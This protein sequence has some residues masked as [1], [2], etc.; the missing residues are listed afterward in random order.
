MKNSIRIRITFMLTLLIIFIIGTCFALN[1]TFLSEY[2]LFKQ[3][4]TL[5]ESFTEINN[6]YAK[7]DYLQEE[8]AD[9]MELGFEKIASNKNM[10][11]CIWDLKV[12][13]AFSTVPEYKLMRM[14]EVLQ[15]YMFPP[16]GEVKSEV[17]KTT[18]DYV[19][20][21]SFDSRMNSY[22]IDLYGTLSNGYKILLRLDFASMQDNVVISNEFLLYVGLAAIIIGTIA[23]F[24]ISANIT[25]PILELSN[26][27]EK[28]SK[29]DFDAK[30]EVKT[31]DEIGKLGNSINFLSAEL[32]ATISE[33]KN[34]NN[35]L[36]KDIEH[37]TQIDEM[38]KDFLSNV[39]HEL[40][41][42]IALI[43]GYAEGLKDNIN[44]DEESREF[45][46]D[47]IIDESK[48]MNN[49]VKKL[50]S[51]NQIEFGQNQLDIIRFDIVL[52]IKSVLESTEILFSQKEAK[53]YF[54][55]KNPVY[56]WADEFMI[57]EVITNFIS[58]ALNHLSGDNT[59]EI[60]I[61]ENNNLVRVSVFNTGENIPIE[62]IDNIWIKFYKVD[63]ARTREYGG[64]GIGL[65][66][67][68][69][70][71]NS[72]NQEFGV[73]NYSNGVEFWF[74]LDAN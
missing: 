41:T 72:H 71:M 50:L 67:V 44:D 20:I 66:I 69:A 6:A 43:Q 13:Y 70:I 58:N 56:V 17:L 33:L 10:D 61:K 52:L 57:E 3:K 22:Y 45:Y 30:Y 25:K 1:S 42:P 53:L 35:E 46:C 31:Q 23:M 39:S 60:K 8:N 51:L 38:R 47:V 14:L 24:F 73:T 7:H 59:I 63:K 40:K 54:N 48:K 68:K 29:L 74:E 37:K 62:D 65:S 15:N 64:S 34:A 32:K 21:K 9:D 27:A 11:I 4:S 19:L 36:L 5:S 2:Y 55:D 16:E 18:N 26:I 49:M 12:F 28:I